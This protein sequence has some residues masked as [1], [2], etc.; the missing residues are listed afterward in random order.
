[1]RYHIPRIPDAV[2]PSEAPPS[3]APPSGED[4]PSSERPITDRWVATDGLVAIGPVTLA[5]LLREIARGKLHSSALARHESWQV[6]RRLSDV[7]YLSGEDRN[8]AT[9]SFAEISAAVDERASGPHSSPPPPPSSAELTAA[10]N[11]SVPPPASS[12]RPVDP[13]GV[14]AQARSLSDAMLLTLS[15]AVAAAHADVGLYHRPRPD[16]DTFIV[17]GAHGSGAELLLGERL[18]STDPTVLAARS[19][20]TVVAEPHPGEVGRHVMGRLSR[21][22]SAP[23]G[24]AMVPLMHDGAVIA[25]FEIARASRPFS[26]REV[27]RIEEIVQALAERILVTGW[28]V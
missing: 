3:E 13:I 18:A 21:C 4:R 19:G 24:A 28:E 5:T 9:Q 8:R 23:R 22:I 15:T 11:D 2:R 6:W 7:A 27:A 25:V 10:A 1:M 26:A 16:L 14:L 17:A 20:I 12:R